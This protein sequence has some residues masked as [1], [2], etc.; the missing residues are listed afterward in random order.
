MPTN[1]VTEYDTLV[2][3]WV[4][5]EMTVS[6]IAAC[7]PT[8][9]PIYTL[10]IYARLKERIS[11]LSSLLHYGSSQEP[12]VMK[13]RQTSNHHHKTHIDIIDIEM[14]RILTDY[15]EQATR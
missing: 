1:S 5:L 8:L 12:V 7:L 13:P 2:Q 6:L 14:A 11:S 4:F 3:T 15:P 9:A 10:S